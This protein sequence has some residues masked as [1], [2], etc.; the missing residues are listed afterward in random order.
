MRRPVCRLLL[1]VAVAATSACASHA[2]GPV[3]AGAKPSFPDIGYATWRQDEPAYRL[4]PG[5]VLDVTVPSAP[6][7]NRTVT[8]E[9]D[10]RISLPLIAPAMAADRSVPE[11]QQRL[12]EAYS[13]QLVHSDIQVDVKTATPLRVFVGGEVGKPGVYDMPGDIDALQAVMM[14]GGFTTLARTN[15]VVIVRRGS[16]GL[17]MRTADLRRATFHAGQADAVPLRRF[18]V[19][20]VPRTTIANLGLFVQQYI[21]DVVPIQ[22]SYAVSPNAYANIP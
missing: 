20:Y 21:R 6:E 2:G 22:F 15:Q 17:M 1:L 3:V 7:L 11:L 14:A 18:D 5:D 4:Y 10:G 9:P 12:T 8:V 19:V 16:N 13:T